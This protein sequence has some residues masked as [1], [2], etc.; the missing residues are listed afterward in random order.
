M[1]KTWLRGAATFAAMALTV[2]G[3]GAA[4]AQEQVTIN[5]ALWDWSATPYYQPLIDA[6]E[7]THPN[8]K[9]TYTD[10]GSTDYDTV[11]QTQLTGGDTNLDVITIKFNPGYSN[12]ISAKLLTPNNNN[13]KTQKNDPSLYGGVLVALTV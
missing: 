6:Y 8:V 5:W 9:I 1:T 3:S 7:A 11:L 13:N 2:A 12:L 10:L 4:I